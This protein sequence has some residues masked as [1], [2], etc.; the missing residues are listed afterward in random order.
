MTRSPFDPA[1]QELPDRLAIFPLEGAL[2]L[3]GGQLPLNIFE[4]RYLAMV[5]DALKGNRLI[6]MVQP[7]EATEE[8]GR[9]PVYRIGCCGRITA[10]SETEDQ[11][12]LITLN[13]LIRFEVGE[14]LPIERGYRRVMVDFARFKDDMDDN[15]QTE[16][17]EDIERAA[18]LDALRRYFEVNGLQ[19][20]WDI[21]EKTQDDR[22]VTSLAMVCPFAPS[23]KQALLE[24]PTLAERADTMLAILR[25]ALLEADDEG[26]RH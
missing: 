12:Y 26:L 13:G 17:A 9:G 3:P 1:F 25:L 11:R 4:P 7:S 10:F 8:P 22:L 16:T 20:D 5:E 24:A 21:I 6:G 23:E 2:L 18:L 15:P 19:G 14:E